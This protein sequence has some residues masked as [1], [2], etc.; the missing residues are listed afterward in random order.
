MVVNALRRAWR[1]FVADRQYGGPAREAYLSVVGAARQPLLYSAYHVPDTVDGRFEMIVLHAV[2]VIRQTKTLGEA[3][4]RFGREFMS[5]LFDDMD[6][7]L[8][9]MGTGDMRVGRR[10]K[11]M[12]EAFYG[13]A[14]AYQD[15]LERQG[16]P[17]ADV[18]ARNVYPDGAPGG[19]IVPAFA[20]LVERQARHLEGTPQDALLAG[21]VSFLPVTMPDAAPM[22]RN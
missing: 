6:R 15:A 3:G 20:A 7:N 5:Y 1:N 13:R 19:G 9:E 17:L 14:G 22:D 18:L 21:K 4:K 12:A 16:T 2:L 11:E 8:R 10:I